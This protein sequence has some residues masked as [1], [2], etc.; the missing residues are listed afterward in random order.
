MVPER[1]TTH[2]VYLGDGLQDFRYPMS[3]KELVATRGEMRASIA[4]MRTRLRDKDA[5]SAVR[6]DFD[7]TEDLE[8]CGFCAYR[9]LCGR[10]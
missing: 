10:E 6:E 3:E 7:M 8:K 2:L 4:A 5:N 9:R 1:V